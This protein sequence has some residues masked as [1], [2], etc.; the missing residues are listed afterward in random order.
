MPAP[1]FAARQQFLDVLNEFLARGCMRWQ[2]NVEDWRALDDRRLREAATP[3][4]IPSFV[5][6]CLDDAS[7]KLRLGFEGG[8]KGPEAVALHTR[9]VF[10]NFINRLRDCDWYNNDEIDA[11][12]AYFD[13]HYWPMEE[14]WLLRRKADQSRKKLFSKLGGPAVVARIPS[15]EQAFFQWAREVIGAAYDANDYQHALEVAE[16]VVLEASTQVA[17]SFDD[18][19]VVLGLCSVQE[20]ASIATMVRLN[21]W[22]DQPTALLDHLDQVVRKRITP[23]MIVGP[24][25]NLLGRF[26]TN[27]T[28]LRATCRRFEEPKLGQPSL[29]AIARMLGYIRFHQQIRRQVADEAQQAV[30]STNIS[31]M[32]TELLNLRADWLRSFGL[33][34]RLR[35]VRDFENVARAQLTRTLGDDAEPGLVDATLSFMAEPHRVIEDEWAATEAGVASPLAW[36]DVSIALLG[37]RARVQSDVLDLPDSYAWLMRAKQRLDGCAVLLA[38]SDFY[39]VCDEYMQ[40]R[41]NLTLCDYALNNVRMLQR[42]AGNARAVKGYEDRVNDVASRRQRRPPARNKLPD[43]TALQWFLRDGPPP[44][45]VP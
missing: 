15:N 19:D 5:T 34:R 17:T 18:R 10:D 2:A 42:R 6:V 33:Y 26:A 35:E 11:L 3:L 30:D 32:L 43:D 21:C 13:T 20:A 1:H 44:L 12:K 40:G 8:A 27:L 9:R 25:R 45:A 41:G 16:A 29:D 39:C 23:A 36:N 24:D 31:L 14:P 4:K 7:S 22:A 28:T 38:W 37:A